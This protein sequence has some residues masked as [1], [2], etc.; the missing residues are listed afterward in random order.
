MPPKKR[1][2]E[3]LPSEER[4]KEIQKKEEKRKEY[5]ENLTS[6]GWDTDH[7]N[8]NS[9]SFSFIHPPKPPQEFH[10]PKYTSVPLFFFRIFTPDFLCH[11]RMENDLFEN[12]NGTKLPPSWPALL[13]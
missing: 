9:L 12:A 7:L 4:V 6:E 11:F 13:L 3:L 5:L 1:K 8:F 10:L 2:A